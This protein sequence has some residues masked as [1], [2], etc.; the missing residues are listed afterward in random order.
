MAERCPWHTLHERCSQQKDHDGPCTMVA[1]EVKKYIELPFSPEDVKRG[2]NEVRELC[3]FVIG[4]GCG[5]ET[6]RCNA[7]KGHDG[8][9]SYT[10]VQTYGDTRGTYAEKNYTQRDLDLAVLEARSEEAKHARQRKEWLERGYGVASDEEYIA[11]LEADL[12]KQKAAM[13]KA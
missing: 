8:F 13:G 4:Q 7:A 11:N 1:R 5:S 12:Q 2:V 9:H 6:L 10:W 3:G